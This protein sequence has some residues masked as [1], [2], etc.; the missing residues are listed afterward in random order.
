MQIK[1]RALNFFANMGLLGF[2]FLF[3]ELAL[4]LVSVFFVEADL[5]TRPPWWVVDTSV[6]MVVDD[7]RL[8]TRGNPE[9]R[10]HD[11]RGFR[12]HSA[13]DSATIVALGDSHTYGTNVSPEATWPGIL[14]AQLGKDVYN[15]GLGGYGPA[16]NNENL[17]IAI[18][19]KPKWII[20]GLYFGNDFYDDF[21]FAQRNGRLSEYASDDVLVEISELENRRTIAEE[22]G[23]LF[24]GGGKIKDAAT[25]RSPSEVLEPPGLPWIIRKWLTDHS[26]LY[27]LLRT[28]MVRFVYD[29]EINALL[30]RDF[31]KAKAN[32]T[33]RQLP[34]VSIYDGL[35]WQTIFTSPYRFRVM[36]DAD[37]RIR[38][39]IE[40][41]KH[42][43]D[44][45]RFR[46]SEIGAKFVVL[47]LPTKEYVFWP[48]VEDPLEH[49]S[50]IELVRNEDRIRNEIQQYMQERG[51]GFIDPAADLRKSQRQPY[52]PDGN[53]H[54]N[55]FGHRVIADKVLEFIKKNEISP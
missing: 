24:L 44:R 5:I 43:L 55:A 37:P 2:S 40:I 23:F 52:F 17:S 33:D 27:G 16:H 36:D 25:D 50:L 19:L 7:D 28:L 9:W 47:L 14:S 54:P 6:P 53:G 42:M 51:I 34:F 30:A 10:E 21:R 18:E 20:F 48:R 29:A 8:G 32:L 22:M 41:S 31:H 11:A 45:M 46:A 1:N 3:V 39:G 15:M 35:S 12:N 4:Q 26:K 13:L 49:K 38:T